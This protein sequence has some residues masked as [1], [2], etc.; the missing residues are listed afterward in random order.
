M[1]STFQTVTLGILSWRAPET[2]RASLQTYASEDLFSLFARVVIYFQEISQADRALAAEFGLEAHGNQANSGIFG[3]VEALARIADTDH[4]LILENDCPL[5]ET[6]ET[7]ARAIGSALED[8][9]AL[10]LPVFRMRSR[11]DPGE[12]FTRLGKYVAHF[13][14]REPLPGAALPANPPAWRAWLR[15]TLRPG[16][17]RAL[18]AS[19]IYAEACPDIRQP[20]AISRSANGNWLTRSGFIN[21]SNQSI[22]VRRDWL[23]SVILERVRTH[24]S[25]RP[26]NGFQDIER[27]VNGP[28][29]RGQNIAIGVSEPGLF[30]HRRLDR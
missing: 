8:M 22:L 29:W 18:R 27:A 28:W 24:P 19:A 4:L 16:K 1:N 26:V 7:A 17:A 11:R 20:R 12:K 21:W 13:P 3:G 9:A 2:L 30:S 5:V 10:D 15:R 23:E 14:V 6:R 25:S